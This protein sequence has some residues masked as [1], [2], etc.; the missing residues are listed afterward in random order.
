M[1]ASPF[2]GIAAAA[3]G[4]KK[5][6]FTDFPDNLPLLDR[7]IVANKLTDV[8]STAPLT[9]GSKLD[10]E[11]SNF[12]LVLATDVMYY[13]DAVEPLLLTLQNLSGKGT[14][15]FMAYGRNRQAES[16]FMTAVEESTLFMRKL[17]ASE[18][19]DVYQC[20]DV[21]V[22]ELRTRESDNGVM[23]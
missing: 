5:T 4:A 12:D 8:A 17:A 18:L 1:F 21:D 13:D 10:L 19:D 22:Y 20:V 6:I 3:L 14:R 2:T 9:W 7:N 11:V 16:T 15:I 23:I